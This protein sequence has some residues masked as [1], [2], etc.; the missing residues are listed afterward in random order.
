MF[1]IGK[2]DQSFLISR[3]HAAGADDWMDAGIDG[4]FNVGSNGAGIGEIDPD[5]CHVCMKLVIGV[6]YLHVGRQVVTFWI[7]VGNFRVENG[8]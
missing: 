3:V 2:F 4:S 6:E 5:I 1:G 7:K 8:A